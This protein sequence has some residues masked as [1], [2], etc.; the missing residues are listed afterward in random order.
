MK[1]SELKEIVDK[2]VRNGN[3]EMEIVIPDN[4]RLMTFKK[5]NKMEINMFYRNGIEFPDVDTGDYC[6][7]ENTVKK[8][9]LY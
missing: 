9:F 4:S 8:L 3:G 1:V 5:L 2:L 6:D 7:K